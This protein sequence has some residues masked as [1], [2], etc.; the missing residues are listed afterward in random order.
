[1]LLHDLSQRAN[2]TDVALQAVSYTM[3]NQNN[4]LSTRRFSKVPGQYRALLLYLWVSFGPI[5]GC[6]PSDS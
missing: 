4:S 5:R 2:T 6:T 3:L 1:M